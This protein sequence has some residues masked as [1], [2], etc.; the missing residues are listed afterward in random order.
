MARQLY[1]AANLVSQTLI[2]G[3]LQIVYADAKGNLLEAECTS[4]GFPYFLGVACA[5]DRPRFG[6]LWRLFLRQVPCES[7]SPKLPLISHR[8]DQSFGV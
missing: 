1:L 3:H 6:S 7:L 5:L 4:S 2:Y 8:E